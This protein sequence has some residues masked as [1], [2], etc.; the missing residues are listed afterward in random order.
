M[1]SFSITLSVADAD[2]PRDTTTIDVDVTVSS[3]DN[4]HGNVYLNYWSTPDAVFI[5]PTSDTVYVPKNGSVSTTVSVG[6]D[7]GD[8][9]DFV[10]FGTADD[11]ST[12]SADINLTG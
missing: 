12:A 11:E 7:P 2:A 3:F 4:F 1:G 10:A 6:L 9:V 8:S 5:D